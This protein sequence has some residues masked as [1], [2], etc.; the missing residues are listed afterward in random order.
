MSLYSSVYL[1]VWAIAVQKICSPKGKVSAIDNGAE[2]KI[3]ECKSLCMVV[4]LCLCEVNIIKLD[5]TIMIIRFKKFWWQI[6]LMD[7]QRL[8]IFSCNELWTC[9]STRMRRFFNEVNREKWKI[10]LLSVW[11]LKCVGRSEENL[12]NWIS[13]LMLRIICTQYTENLK[14]I[15]GIKVVMSRFVSFCEVRKEEARKSWYI[16]TNST[17]NFKDNKYFLN[18]ISWNRLNHSSDLKARKRE[19]EWKIES[20]ESII[21]KKIVKKNGFCFT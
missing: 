21:S 8:M 13:R 19:T 5:Y 14:T 16:N 12:L 6:Q 7:E 18:R 3:A 4:C 10:V 17:E 20:A 11:S 1:R 2:R 9:K 15:D